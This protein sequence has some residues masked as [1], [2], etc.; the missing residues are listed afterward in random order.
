LKREGRLQEAL[1]PGTD[2]LPWNT[3]AIDQYRRRWLVRAKFKSIGRIIQ[4][5]KAAPDHFNLETLIGC[6]ARLVIEHRTTDDA[7]TWANITSILHHPDRSLAVPKGFTR[8]PHKEPE[9]EPEEP[10]PSD[11][12]L[13][14]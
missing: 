2:A 10:N 13:V 9:K 5:G 6:N 7:R 11:D 14:A 1:L 4:L 8:E 12:Y 3:V